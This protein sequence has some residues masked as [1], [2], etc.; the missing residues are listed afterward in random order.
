MGKNEGRIPCQ[1]LG[2]FLGRGELLFSAGGVPCTLML[3]H[4]Y[5]KKA[6]ARDHAP[7][8]ILLGE[9]EQIAVF[10]RSESVV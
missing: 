1:A 2:F 7:D 5:Q 8:I 4:T 3:K 10:A 9:D 6:H